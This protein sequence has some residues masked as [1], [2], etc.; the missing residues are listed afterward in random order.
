M[1]RHT[2]SG[3]NLDPGGS[4]AMPLL[5]PCGVTREDIYFTRL[6]KNTFVFVFLINVEI[7][8]FRQVLP[9]VQY[10]ALSIVS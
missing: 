5:P 6:P 3:V 9:I 4:H 8:I 7:F 10:T 1:Y 2:I